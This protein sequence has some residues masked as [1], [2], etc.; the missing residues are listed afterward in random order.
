MYMYVALI[1][2]ASLFYQF[3]LNFTI[4]SKSKYNAFQLSSLTH[5]I[6]ENT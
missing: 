5:L 4:F 6:I 3:Y 2:K 1:F